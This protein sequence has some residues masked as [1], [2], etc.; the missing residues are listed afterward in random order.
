MK[1]LK[2]EGVTDRK[3]SMSQ[4]QTIKDLEWFVNSASLLNFL[5]VENVKIKLGH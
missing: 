2:K 1:F 3:N 4:A 5:R